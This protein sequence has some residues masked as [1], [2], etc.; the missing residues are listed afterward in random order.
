MKDNQRIK[1]LV[2]QEATYQ[3][4]DELLDSF[5]NSMNEV[6]LDTYDVLTMCGEVDSNIYILKEGIMRHTF[7]NGEKIITYSFALPGTMIVSWHS[8]Y[9]HKPAFFQVEACCKSKVLKMKKAEFDHFITKSHEFSQWLVSMLQCQLYFYEMK[10]AV[11]NGDA[12][13]RFLSLIKS[14]PEILQ[15]VPLK[16]IA[17]Y[18]GITQ[19]YLS[20]LRKRIYTA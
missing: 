8:Y 4:P 12:E 10:N 14:R 16:I 5:L 9:F 20:R 3:L 2:K 17:S 7:L 19:S 11:I 18:L 13:S 6:E 1:E 15:K